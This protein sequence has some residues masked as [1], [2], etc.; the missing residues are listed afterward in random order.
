M[1]LRRED[2]ESQGVRRE[3][4]CHGGKDDKMTVSEWMWS[5]MAEGS[6]H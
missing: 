4:A 2:L 3:N 1:R 6:C 5:H